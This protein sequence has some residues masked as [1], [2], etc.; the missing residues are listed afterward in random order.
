MIGRH[1]TN[2]QPPFGNLKIGRIGLLRLVLMSKCGTMNKIRKIAEENP[3]LKRDLTAS[4][5]TPIDFICNTFSRQS[6]KDE[7]FETFT[8]AL[9]MEM[10][11]F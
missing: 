10:R 2:F 4:L 8:A 3:T 9:E 6:F 5:Q 1:S 7:P 11:R